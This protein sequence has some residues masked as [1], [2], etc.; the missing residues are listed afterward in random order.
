V[1]DEREL[2]TI[3]A[4]LPSEWRW[5]G[6]QLRGALWSIRDICRLLDDPV[7]Q[8][9]T[10]RVQVMRLRMIDRALELEATVERLQRRILEIWPDPP[11]SPCGPLIPNSEIVINLRELIRQRP[12]SCA[13]PPPPLK[14][15]ESARAEHTGR[16]GE[17][18][19]AVHNVWRRSLHSPS[20][21][22]FPAQ[23]S[24]PAFLRP[25]R[26]RR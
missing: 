18:F 23:I 26:G 5:L 21:E 22:Y 4:R 9:D 7:T 16:S 12:F 6:A 17:P 8:V 25:R 19:Q 10:P 20:S 24:A 15:V 1:I 2:H 11:R 3:A 14:N 13:G